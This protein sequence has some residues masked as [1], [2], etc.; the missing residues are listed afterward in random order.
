MIEEPSHRL[1]CTFC[2]DNLK[3]T[4]ACAL[5]SVHV[6][7]NIL[8]YHLPQSTGKLKRYIFFNGILFEF[9]T[10]VFGTLNTVSI[11]CFPSLC[12]LHLQQ[13][14]F[15]QF[16]I[17]NKIRFHSQIIALGSFSPLKFDSIHKKS[18]QWHQMEVSIDRPSAIIQNSIKKIIYF[19]QIDD[20]NFFLKIV[21]KW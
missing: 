14:Q 15:S 9:W 10:I 5:C 7:Y 16:V 11:V 17:G 3:T 8:V 19:H 4:V 12:L 2:I 13:T 21:S 20:I 1:Y 6:D 18:S